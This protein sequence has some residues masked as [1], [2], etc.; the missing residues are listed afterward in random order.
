VSPH[1]LEA[2]ITGV[3]ADVRDFGLTSEPEPTIY[4]IGVSSE[5]QILVQTDDALA[6][7]R[8]ARAILRANPE[9]APGPVKPLGDYVDASL[10]RQRFVLVLMGVFAALAMV[11]CVVGTYGVFSYSVTLRTREFGIR[12]AI[13][14][15][16][17][18]LLRQVARECVTVV[19]PALLVGC[20]I[21]FASAGFLSALL[22]RVS[23]ADP[24]S[25]GIAGGALLLLCVAAVLQ[26]A[27]RAAN[28]DPANVLREQ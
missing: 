13:G 2:E 9:Q 24:L 7:T 16:K 14:A 23:P 25:F 26:P 20:G 4:S 18:T 15:Q 12:S 5:M 22:Y 6:Y 8:I 11:L 21:S 27:W 17:S 3:V 28:V 1:T 19:V 10:A